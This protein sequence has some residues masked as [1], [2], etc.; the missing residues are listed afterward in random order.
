MEP[1][2]VWPGPPGVA[3]IEQQRLA[4]LQQRDYLCLQ[5][6]RPLDVAAQVMTPVLGSGALCPRNRS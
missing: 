5:L 1:V 4:L 2:Q 6:G 3:V